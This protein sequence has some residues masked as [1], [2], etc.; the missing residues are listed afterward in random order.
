M[1]RLPGELRLEILGDLL[2]NPA[3]DLQGLSER[4][5]VTDTHVL[6]VTLGRLVRR[7]WVHK[8]SQGRFILSATGRAYI[9]QVRG[10]L[11]AQEQTG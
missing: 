1:T 3:S 4:I 6:R 10:W 8:M 9:G 2:R 5:S 7:G 11:D